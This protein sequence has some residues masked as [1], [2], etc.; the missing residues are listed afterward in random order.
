VSDAGRKVARIVAARS[1]FISDL[2]AMIMST[3]VILAAGLALLYN[4]KAWGGWADFVVALLAAA[5]GTLTLTPLFAAVDTL[6]SGTGPRR[7]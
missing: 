5:G 6:A 7:A 3:I 4:G 2:L 1:L